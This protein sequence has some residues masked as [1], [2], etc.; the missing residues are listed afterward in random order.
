MQ[1]IFLT[2]LVIWCL[3]ILTLLG[4]ANQSFSQ[5]LVTLP[6][7]TRTPMVARPLV[8]ARTQSQ[9]NLYFNYL[10]YYSPEWYWIDRPLFFDRSLA[11]KGPFPKAE[12]LAPSFNRII[13]SAEPYEID[14]F[15]HLTSAGSSQV[16]NYLK[17]LDISSERPHPFPILMALAPIGTDVDKAVD[18]ISKLLDAA[19]ASPAAPRIDGKILM[20]SYSLDGDSVQVWSQVIHKLHQKYGNK[21]LIVAAI[22]R[23][24]WAPYMSGKD[25]KI[26]ADQLNVL[27]S[28]LR[29]WLDV[30]DGIIYN[31]VG[32]ATDPTNDDKLDQG[33][34]EYITRVCDSVL[35]EP[36][37]RKK[38]FGLSAAV[39]Y[40]NP[41]TSS[42]SN[43]NATKYL[44]NSLRI[45][46]AAHPDFIILPEWDEVNENTSFEPTVY[47]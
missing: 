10:H 44:R 11:P 20:S 26:P 36:A 38:Y 31:G 34:Y 37:Y 21:F 19:L 40:F 6:A 5:T 1:K 45:A 42:R 4:C 24:W 32:H 28:N 18:N 13:D 3:F 22:A 27:K 35:S 14:G 33:F 29:S 39:G 9:Y 43:E 23:P 7:A 25:G 8:F 30:F 12:L 46:L 17:A 15:S 2:K 47:N 41:I 16:A